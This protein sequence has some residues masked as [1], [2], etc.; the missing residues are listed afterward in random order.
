[1]YVHT[2]PLFSYVKLLYAYWYIRAYRC[3]SAVIG[4]TASVDG[5]PRA[6]YEHNERCIIA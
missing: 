6:M 4:N 2:K 3:L 1:M 5:E